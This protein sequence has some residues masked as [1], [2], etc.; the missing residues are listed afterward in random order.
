MKTLLLFLFALTCNISLSAQGVD[1]EIVVEAQPSELISL[2]IPQVCDDSRWVFGGESSS[3]DYKVDSISKSVYL[4]AKRDCEILLVMSC[5]GDQRLVI[6]RY[7]IRVGGS[8]DPEPEPEPTPVD[9][10]DGDDTY[11]LGKFSWEVSRPINQDARA[12]FSSTLT[13]AQKRLQGVGGIL[14][15]N[16]DL[17]DY[18]GNNSDEW[19]KPI[20]EKLEARKNEPLKLKDWLAM[21]EEIKEAIK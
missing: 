18:L 14:F 2:S 13:V 21:L 8:P 16:R 20:I 10:F 7:V 1:Q 17:F 3:N 5:E 11:G 9:E 15:V 12:K 4:V 19:A 6:Y